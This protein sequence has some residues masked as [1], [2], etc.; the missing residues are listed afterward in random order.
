MMARLVAENTTVQSPGSAPGVLIVI[1]LR[2][3]PPNSNCAQHEASEAPA[4]QSL[5]QLHH[6][7]IKAILLDNKE[8]RANGVACPN[9]RIGII[10]RQRHRL[11][12][13]YVA[14]VL[15]EGDYVFR[16]PAALGKN[17]D[18]IRSYHLHHLVHVIK[19]RYRELPAD[20]LCLGFI[21][22][23]YSRQL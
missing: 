15:G 14:T 9:H 17:H 3:T 16:V 10:E 4:F 12:D 1:S 20:T 7:N 22:I 18:D 11:L 19:V 23:A 8:A 2:A 5:A 13:D 21:R 6:G